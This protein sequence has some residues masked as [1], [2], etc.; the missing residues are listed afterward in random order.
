MNG[1]GIRNISRVLLLSPNR[2]LKTLRQAAAEVSEPIAPRRVRDMEIDEFWSFVGTKKQ[3]R[4]TWYR[5]DR[6]RRKVVAFVN[7]RRTDAACE[8]LPKKLKGCRVG[9]YH[10]DDSSLLKSTSRQKSTRLAKKE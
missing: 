1:S 5:F 4:W 10:T 6:K 7:G 9:R 3:E 2:V 8:L